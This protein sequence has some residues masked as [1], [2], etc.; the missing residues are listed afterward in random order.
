ME[1]ILNSELVNASG[2][3][4]LLNQLLDELFR[5]KHKVLLFSQFTTMLDIIEVCTSPQYDM[6]YP[7]NVSAGLGKGTQALGDLQN[8]W[9][10]AHVD[11]KGGGPTLPNWR[12][13]SRRAEAVLVEY[14]GGWTRAELGCG[15]HSYILRSRLGM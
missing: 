10:D 8:R 1:P 14:P 11:T 5:R 13:R 6:E 3:M 7:Q 15:R 4:M 9:V 2:K 12:R